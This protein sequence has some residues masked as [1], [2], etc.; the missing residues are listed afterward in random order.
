MYFILQRL[1]EE[2]KIKHEKLK[3]EMI[4]INIMQILYVVYITYF[5]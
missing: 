1:P 5:T 2:I 4:G 3:E